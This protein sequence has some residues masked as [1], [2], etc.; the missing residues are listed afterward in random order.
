MKKQ[1]MNITDNRCPYC[2]APFEIPPKGVL[3]FECKYC[4]NSI[5]LSYDS[6][7]DALLAI[8]QADLDLKN[9][10]IELRKT[11]VKL[12]REDVRLK[13]A[14]VKLKEA[15]IRH[16]RNKERTKEKR[17]ENFGKRVLGFLIILL[18]VVVDLAVLYFQ[19]VYK[20]FEN[21]EE[22]A[23]TIGLL[24]LGVAFMAIGLIET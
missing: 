16:A 4:G 20:I 8:K 6:E 5:V 22:T 18:I 9:A 17:R 19:S 3:K 7:V 14:D 13:N 23:K 2:S 10:D 24:S 11:D 21:T 1:E 15:E 12:R